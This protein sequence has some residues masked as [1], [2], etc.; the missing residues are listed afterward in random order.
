MA[1]KLL[2][3]IRR[4]LKVSSFREYR[5][6]NRRGPQISKNGVVGRAA[7]GFFDFTGFTNP[8]IRNADNINGQYAVLEEVDHLIHDRRLVVCP[9]RARKDFRAVVDR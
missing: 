9:A 1:K 8:A 4:S 3:S 7:Y 6:L 5:N 2:L